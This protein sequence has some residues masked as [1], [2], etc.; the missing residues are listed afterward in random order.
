[1][2]FL[3]DLVQDQGLEYFAGETDIRVDICLQE[4]ATYAEAT[5][6]YTLGNKTGL[7]A[8]A[9]EDGDTDGRKVVIPAITDGSVTGTDT[10]SHWAVSD[11]SGTTLIAANTLQSSQPVTNGNTFTLDAIDITIRDP[12]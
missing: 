8:G 4:P 1:M 3:N 9:T 12:S 11:V 6:T 2:P 10:A 7:T 5:S